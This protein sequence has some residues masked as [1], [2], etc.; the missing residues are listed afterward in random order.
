[1]ARILEKGSKK[2]TLHAKMRRTAYLHTKAC[3]TVL[4]MCRQAKV[5]RKMC[6]ERM[7]GQAKWVDEGLRSKGVGPWQLSSNTVSHGPWLWTL[8]ASGSNKMWVRVASSAL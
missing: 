2:H 5:S 1:M 7:R 8:V 6:S 3:P 4:D